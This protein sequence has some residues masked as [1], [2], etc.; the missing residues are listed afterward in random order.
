MHTVVVTLALVVVSLVNPARSQ[1]NPTAGRAKGA[2]VFEVGLWPGEG[3]PRL[4]A[5]TTTLLPNTEPRKDAPAGAVLHVK[6]GQLLGFGQTVYR[7]IVP[8]RLK[9]LKDAQVTGRRLGSIL[10]LSRDDYYSAS[11]PTASLPVRA[12]EFIDYLQD[13]AEGSCFVRIRGEV[14]DA[15]PCPHLVVHPVG[16][17]A[18]DAEPQTEW[19]V[20]VM[21]EGRPDGWLLVDGRNV[22]EEGRTF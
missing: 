14:V 16:Q 17:I 3:R 6:K 7:T 5:G 20:Q 9:V 22:R 10:R 4:V 15:D 2:G 11:Y 8:G 18:L 13:R 1:D 21:L 12:G 19:W